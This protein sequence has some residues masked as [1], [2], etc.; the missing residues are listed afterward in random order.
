M[1]FQAWKAWKHAKF[2]NGGWSKNA[3]RETFAR[4]RDGLQPRCITRDLRWGVPV[5]HPGFDEKVFYV[6]FDAP[7]GYISI[8]AAYTP[9]WEQWWRAPE[10]VE[11][12]Q[13]LGKDNIQFHTL[14]FPASLL[15]TQDRWTLLDR[16]SV[17]DYL[18]YEGC[19]FSKS[20][21]IGVFGDQACSTGIHSDV[22]RYY[23]L[24]VRPESG[25]DADFTWSD[26]KAKNNGDLLN[27]LG[28]FCHRVLDFIG[29]RCNGLVPAVSSAG[30]AEC[31]AL[32]KELKPLVDLYIN[33]LENCRLREALKA[34][35]AVSTCG[36]SFLSTHEPWKKL[37]THPQEAAA[38]LA[39]G[40]GVVRLLA[41]LLAP[42]V[43]TVAGLLLHFL[44]LPAACGCLSDE[45]LSAVEH[46]HQ[47]V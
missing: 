13:F 21:K 9:E 4:L 43:P 35:L 24:S 38:Y 11:L 1:G 26:L 33:H 2:L 47:I 14:N 40:A 27:N 16:I 20:R 37:A 32:G 41:A 23:L 5:P 39:S 42:F 29:K 30:I 46:P 25:N 45:L 44:G 3:R 6:W 34:A 28:N 19:K 10:N 36:N 18:N 17:T 8:T 7:I 22:F 15:A 31:L 12:V